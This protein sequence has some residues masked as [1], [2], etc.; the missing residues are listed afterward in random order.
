MN[1]SSSFDFNGL[2][3][4]RLPAVGT[5]HV[6][7]SVHEI[8]V[9]AKGYAHLG[10]SRSRR[11]YRVL[12]AMPAQDW[13]QSNLEAL[14][15]KA[16]WTEPLLARLKLA[17]SMGIVKWNAAAT[18]VMEKQQTAQLKARAGRAAV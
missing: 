7:V 4:E 13:E 12:S 6:R 1:R 15:I 14:R 2:I 8:A 16:C 17:S 5:I 18:I 10:F 3:L 11:T 9:R